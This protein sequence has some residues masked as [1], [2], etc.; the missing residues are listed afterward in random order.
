MTY[1]LILFICQAVNDLITWIGSE[2]QVL[3]EEN[4]NT[5]SP[6]TPIKENKSISSE[7]VASTD[8]EKISIDI[9]ENPSS[10][11]SVVLTYEEGP[12]PQDFFVPYLWSVVVR[13]NLF[14]GISGILKK[15]VAPHYKTR[16]ERALM[17]LYV[18]VRRVL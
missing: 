16:C 17:F 9:I 1:H 5:T 12:T 11:P 3:Y 2:S 6:S 14:F 15:G 4:D 18:S 8:P 7:A 13:L 10:M